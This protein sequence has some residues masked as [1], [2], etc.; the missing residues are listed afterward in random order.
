MCT[1]YSIQFSYEHILQIKIFG[2]E[3][4]IIYIIYIIYIINYI[5]LYFTNPISSK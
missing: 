2:C 3:I 4:F 1:V 5:I